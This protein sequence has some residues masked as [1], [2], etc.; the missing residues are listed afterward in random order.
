M[1]YEDAL[2]ISEMNNLDDC[3]ENCSKCAKSGNC[4]K[5]DNLQKDLG[6]SFDDQAAYK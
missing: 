3:T 5:E 1:S 2:E 6:I 4:K